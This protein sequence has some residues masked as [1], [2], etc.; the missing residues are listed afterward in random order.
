M[1]I[2][3]LNCGSSSIKYQLFN[4]KLIGAQALMVTLVILTGS[5]FFFIDLANVVVVILVS[6]TVFLSV[7]FTMRFPAKGSQAIKIL[8]TPQRLYS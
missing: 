3:V 2:L 4:I 8:H 5:Q 6:V 7:I 1:I